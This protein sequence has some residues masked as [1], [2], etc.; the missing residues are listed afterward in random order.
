MGYPPPTPE[1]P[2]VYKKF[3]DSL[4]AAGINVNKRGNYVHVMALTD[5]DIDQM[6]RGEI[7]KAETLN[8]DTFDPIQG[9]LFD[10]SKTGGHSGTGW[11]HVKLH[12]PIP[13]PVMEEPIRHLLG[14]TEKQYRNV[15]SGES[16]IDGM[17]GGKAI[18][19]ALRRINVDKEIDRQKHILKSGLKSKRDGAVKRLRYLDMFKKTGIKP[20]E[21]VLNKV[22]VLPPQY[23]P[24]SRVEGTKIVSHPNFL[25]KELMLA[26]DNLRDLKDE[27]GEDSVGQERLALYD[28]F[29]S[30]TGLGSPIQPHLQDKNVRGILSHLLGLKSSPK[31]STVQRKVIGTST[32]LVGRAV[33]TPNPSL[34]MDQVGLPEDKAWVLYR[35]FIVRQLVR[36]GVPAMAAARMVADKDP[37]ARDALVDEMSNRPVII[38]RAPTLHRFGIMAAYPIMTKGKT[39]QVPPITTSGFGADF[40]GDAMQFHVPVSDD[41]VR[42]AR[43]RLMPS[44]NLTSVRFFDVHYVP[45]ETGCSASALCWLE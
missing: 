24:I 13:N 43:E 7:T 26:N 15:L 9:G 18:Q 33:I 41:A 44:R 22:P 28:T 17:T 14:M 30:L 23:R 12:E 25:Y 39:L 35:P 34:D 37:K 19:F 32:D 2:F 1:A 4:K 27:L 29:K 40:D 31:F 38:N 20:V 5:N 21:L 8:F 36:R 10:L 16:S 11:S 3:M 6:S 45:G 42:E